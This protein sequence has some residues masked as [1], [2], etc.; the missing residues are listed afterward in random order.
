L[1]C[2]DFIGP[3]IGLFDVGFFAAV[4]SPCNNIYTE[5]FIY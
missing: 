2:G 4:A 1:I 5:R 3:V